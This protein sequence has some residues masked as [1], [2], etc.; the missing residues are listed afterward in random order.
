MV[1]VCFLRVVKLFTK[2]QLR[3]SD[4][5][6]FKFDVIADISNTTGLSKVTTV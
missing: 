3:I 2:Y 1:T 5:F 6:C 4:G